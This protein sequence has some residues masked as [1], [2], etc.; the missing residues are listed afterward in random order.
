MIIKSPINY[1]GSKSVILDKLISLFPKT[2]YFVDL[3]TGGSVYMNVARHYKNVIAND[4]IIH[5]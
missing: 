1:V 4:S 5:K 2:D 3:F